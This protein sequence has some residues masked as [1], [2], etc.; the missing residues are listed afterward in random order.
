MHRRYLDTIRVLER[1]LSGS[2]F[3][4]PKSGIKKCNR[5][6]M[7]TMILVQTGSNVRPRGSIAI[8][9]G[10][11]SIPGNSVRAVGNAESLAE[12]IA[13]SNI[14]CRESGTAGCEG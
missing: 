7:S 13:G 10:A 14:V 4:T 12:N 11:T 6:A 9:E 5:S 2:Q 3:Q 1:D 8:A